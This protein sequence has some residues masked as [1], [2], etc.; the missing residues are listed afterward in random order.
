MKHSILNAIFRYKHTY[1]SNLVSRTDL[2]DDILDDRF[3]K[4]IKLNGKQFDDIGNEKIINLFSK[5]EDKPNQNEILFCFLYKQI[6]KDL[7]TKISE[8]DA[9]IINLDDA[10][11]DTEEKRVV[12]E[13]RTISW[14]K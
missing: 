14:G 5:K 10:Y 9:E 13:I 7:Y 12:I 6:V 1:M 2:T 8:I 3:V 11:Y 4:S